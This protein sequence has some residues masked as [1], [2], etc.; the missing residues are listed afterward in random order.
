MARKTNPNILWL[1]VIK[2]WDSRYIEKKS[3]E[4]P[5]YDFKNIEIWNFLEHFFKKNGLNIHH[6]KVNFSESNV[7]SIFV[8]YYAKPAP[9]PPKPSR[10]RKRRNM[11]SGFNSLNT[12]VGSQS[13]LHLR[14]IKKLTYKIFKT[15][16]SKVY[17]DI[18][19]KKRRTTVTTITK[20]LFT[21]T[22]RRI[23]NCRVTVWAILNFV[24]YS[25]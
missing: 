17:Y 10:H 15:L 6:C 5:F 21:Y 11:P 8:A 24:F 1:G 7:I 22:K 25:N 12:T 20:K 18:K 19:K 4:I 13:Y 2:N 3:S 23:L 16:K 9:T 14:Y